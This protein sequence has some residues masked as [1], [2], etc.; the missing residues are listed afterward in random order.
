M[1]TCVYTCIYVYIH[2]YIYIYTHVYIHTCVLRLAEP[3]QRSLAGDGVLARGLDGAAHHPGHERAYS[4]IVL[5][6]IIRYYVVL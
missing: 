6:Y 5:Y 2:I 4:T 3:A 1:Y